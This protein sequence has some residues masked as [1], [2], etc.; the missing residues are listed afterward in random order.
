MILCQNYKNCSDKDCLHIVPHL[1]P[2][3]ED[4]SYCETED[5][6]YGYKCVTFFQLM[7][8]RAIDKQNN[9]R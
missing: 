2:T 7:M 5:C 6:G 1:S 9:N 4:D 3:E 8:E